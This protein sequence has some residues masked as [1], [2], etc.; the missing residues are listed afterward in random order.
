MS[1][2]TEWLEQLERH[3]PRRAVP[4]IR[5][6]HLPPSFATGKNAEFCALELD[7]GAL[8]LSFILLAGQE[9]SVSPDA[10]RDLVGADALAA[11]RWYVTERGVRRTIG[12]AAINALTR[13][14]YDRAGHVPPTSDDSIGGLAPA[15]G[16][17]IGMIGL[18]PPLV[19]SI[20]RTGASLVVVELRP[21]LAGER[22][23]YRVTLDAGQLEGCNKVLS[24]ST[25]L[26]NDSLD[27]ML[28]HCRGAQRFAMIGPGAGGF[29][30]PL[31]ARGIT[32]L[33]GAWIED[34]EGFKAALAA[35]TPWG[36]HARKFAIHREAWVPIAPGRA[37]LW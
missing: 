11:A 4:R 37:G 28:A 34:P 29:P 24:T 3:F 12:F 2:G 30:D 14:A 25:L 19:D 27:R 7:D 22:A 31:F 16:D 20:V 1:V 6:L 36:R 15:C 32:T 26:L 35:G 8:G 18:F 9:F 5:R 23:G 17:R 33:G 21:D 13:C 10:A